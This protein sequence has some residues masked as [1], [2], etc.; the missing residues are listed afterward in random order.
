MLLWHV[1]INTQLPALFFFGSFRLTPLVA[2][3][4]WCTHCTEP[5]A[6]QNLLPANP[7]CWCPYLCLEEPRVWALPGATWERLLQKDSCRHQ[8]AMGQPHTTLCRDGVLSGD[9]S[10]PFWESMI[11]LC[12]KWLSTYL[13]L[14]S[15][16]NLFKL[17]RSFSI[18]GIPWRK[19]NN[20]ACS[21]NCTYFSPGK[22]TSFQ[23]Y[24]A[25]WL[26]ITIW[27]RKKKYFGSIPW[28]VELWCLERPCGIS[29]NNLPFCFSSGKCEPMQL[30]VLADIRILNRRSM[31]CRVQRNNW[32]CI[33]SPASCGYYQYTYITS[34]LLGWTFSP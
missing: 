6:K 17:R 9:K 2:L 31:T 29:K 13:S 26:K 18:T 24:L 14:N 27:R 22:M 16:E 25:Y 21:E 19:T 20:T 15:I 34:K 33:A 3:H 4:S 8:P 10:K 5:K 28:A 32:G 7:Q 23:H 1:V 12:A 11:C 30:A